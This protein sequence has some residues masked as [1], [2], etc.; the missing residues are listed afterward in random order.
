MYHLIIKIIKTNVILV[1][2]LYYFPKEKASST[3]KKWKGLN[4]NHI[5]KVP[6]SSN[7]PRVYEFY[8][9]RWVTL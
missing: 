1:E 5:G 3:E 7:I 2:R 9:S 8:N 6:F 4:Q